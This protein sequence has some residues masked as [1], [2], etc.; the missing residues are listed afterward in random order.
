MQENIQDK[1]IENSKEMCDRLESEN[2]NRRKMINDELLKYEKNEELFTIAT[3][4]TK[5]EADAIQSVLLKNKIY[6]RIEIDGMFS[7]NKIKH[8]VSV[9]KG[10]IEK[11]T[12]LLEQMEEENINKIEKELPVCPNCK[13]R[14]YMVVEELSLIERLLYVGCKVY[15]C[16]N[17]GKKWGE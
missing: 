13:K 5:Y 11:A 14:E 17:C 2:E 7:R 10:D 3:S 6:S 16:I 9:Y 15:K 1:E 12:L 4:L 8:R